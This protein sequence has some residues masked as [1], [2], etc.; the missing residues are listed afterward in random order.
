MFVARKVLIGFLISRYGLTAT[1][2]FYIDGDFRQMTQTTRSAGSRPARDFRPDIHF[3]N[4]G[5]PS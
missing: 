1:L 5:S 2:V 3:A 4:S